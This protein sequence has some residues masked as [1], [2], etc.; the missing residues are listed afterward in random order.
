MLQLKAGC[1]IS[2][3]N[4]RVPTETAFA[5]IANLNNSVRRQ[6]FQAV[7]TTLIELYWEVGAYIS[8][9]IGSDAKGLIGTAGE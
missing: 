9:K 8:R 2:N 5:E 6:V 1:C 7:N 4:P 3:L